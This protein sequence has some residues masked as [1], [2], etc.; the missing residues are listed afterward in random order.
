MLT[1]EEVKHVAALARIK[2]TDSEVAKFQEDLA[3]ILE[4]FDVLQDA[5]VAG[6]EPMIHSV[7]LKNITRDDKAKEKRQG[8]AELLVQMAPENQDGYVKVKSIL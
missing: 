7:A 8:S 2:L 3:A 6:K 1:K 4:Y 5:D